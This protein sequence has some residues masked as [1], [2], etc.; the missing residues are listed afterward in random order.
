MTT[1]RLG[2]FTV[3]QQLR[4]DNPA[5]AQFVVFI[6]ERLI[7]KSFSMPD[8]GC[9][10]WLERQADLDR[11]VYA[12]DSAKPRVYTVVKNGRP[13]NGEKNRRSSLE[14]VVIT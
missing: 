4:F 1:F 6:G 13:S 2:K 10:E 8:L 3:R 5:F 14:L 11:V 12:K 9:C 7:G